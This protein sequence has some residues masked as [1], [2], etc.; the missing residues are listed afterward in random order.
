MKTIV[1]AL[2]TLLTA[3]SCSNER[4][5]VKPAT[6]SYQFY[7]N[8][9]ADQFDAIE[10]RLNGE[11][12]G[13]LNKPYLMGRQLDCQTEIAGMLLRVERPAGSYSMDA[14]AKLNG[15]SV[16][17]WSGAIRIDAGDCSQSRLNSNQ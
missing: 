9:A 16:S 8:K 14:V 7:T 13:T 10:V 3:V 6:G 2:L 5:E 11:L 15:K 4:N 17:K 1:I 12:V